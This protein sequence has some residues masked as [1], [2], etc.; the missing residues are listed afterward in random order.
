MP[1]DHDEHRDVDRFYCEFGQRLH[2]ARTAAR[3]SQE[4]LARVVGLNRTSISNIEKG[5]QRL[6]A[7]QL[8]VLALA[9]QTTVEELLP[10]PPATDT[11]EGLAEA[12]RNA[13]LAVR[14]ARPVS[15]EVSDGISR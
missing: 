15:Q 14:R 8:P 11:L 12:D 7:H 4:A 6:L 13:V 2:D 1:A 3:V 10:A 9:L 5:R